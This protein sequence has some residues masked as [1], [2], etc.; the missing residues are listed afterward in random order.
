MTDINAIVSIIK[1]CDVKTIVIGLP[2]SLSGS[3]GEQA[4]K[5]ELFAD[6]LVQHTDIPVKLRDERLTTVTAQRIMRSVRKKP[7]KR[8]SHDDD[9]AAA[10]ILQG[11]L[12]EKSS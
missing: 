12:D 11:Y 6:H 3:I 4:L 7:G 8:K 9:A 2:L 5:V 1:Q 10:V